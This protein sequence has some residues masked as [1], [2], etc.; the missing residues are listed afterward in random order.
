[1]AVLLWQN[2]IIVVAWGK[3][4][5]LQV[6]SHKARFPPASDFIKLSVPGDLPCSSARHLIG[7]YPTE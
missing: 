6:E 5:M 3:K 1:M 4:E 2:L 7:K